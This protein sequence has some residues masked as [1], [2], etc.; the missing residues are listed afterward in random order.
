MVFEVQI[1]RHSSSRNKPVTW[2]WPR[3]TRFTD[4]PHDSGE[5]PMR[6]AI[7]VVIYFFSR[8]LGLYVCVYLYGTVL[9]ASIR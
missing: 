8:G 9:A 5:V 7:S 3:P 1:G 4:S 2:T 6:I